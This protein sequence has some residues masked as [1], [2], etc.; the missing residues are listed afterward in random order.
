MLIYTNVRTV[1]IPDGSGTAKQIADIYGVSGDSKPTAGLAT[2][3]TFVEVD[4]GDLYLFN[5]AA[6]T[7]TKVE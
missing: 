6:G 7:W 5:E 3:A 4:T 1:K 2:G